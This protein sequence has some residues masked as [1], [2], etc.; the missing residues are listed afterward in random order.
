[1]KQPKYI[2]ELI[3]KEGFAKFYDRLAKTKDISEREY[4]GKWIIRKL[5]TVYDLPSCKLHIFNEVYITRKTLFGLIKREHLAEYDTKTSEISIWTID[6]LTRQII[7]PEEFF[8]SLIHEFMHHYDWH[9]LGTLKHDKS[10]ES[11]LAH[12]KSMIREKSKVNGFFQGKT[13]E[14]VRT[15]Q[16]RKNYEVKKS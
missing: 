1:M 15:G 13:C 7:V 9:K 10:F 5:C 6:S 8:E 2:P 4:N 16:K 14:A 11:R 12:L 3:D